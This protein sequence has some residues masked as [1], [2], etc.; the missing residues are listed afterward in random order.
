VILLDSDHVSVLLDPRHAKRAGLMARLESADDEL[1]LPIIVVEEQ[2]RGWLAAIHSSRDVYK[3][4]V[5]YV[6]L[7]KL[8]DFLGS[9]TI[10]LWN[11][12]AADEFTA[13]RR[14]RIRIG[15]QDLKIASI[16]LANNALL[17]SANTRDF[18]QVTGL[19]VED[20][21]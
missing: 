7:A 13:L 2:M 21:L 19:R 4:V 10:V 11:E 3:Q 17:L 14:S 18:E 9:W 16:A 12:P 8:V 20:W 15:T 5:P 1:G 6:R